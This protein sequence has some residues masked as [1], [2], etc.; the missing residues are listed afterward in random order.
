VGGQF[1]VFDNST[2]ICVN[3]FS[4]VSEPREVMTEDGPVL[5]GGIDDDIA[6]LQP[7]LAKMASPLQQLDPAVYATLATVIKEEYTKHGHD[8]TVT[9]IWQR[10][11]KGRLTEDRAV[12]QRLLDLADM[13][14]PF[15]KGGA[16]ANYFE[17][18][19]NLD[20]SNSFLVFELQE[21]SSNPHLKGV[22]QM[23][24][25]YR[26]TQ[27]M[28]EERERQ[29]AFILDEAKETLVGNG[30]DDEAM[31]KFLEALYLRVRKYN[32]CAITASQDVAH[33]MASRYGKSIWNQ[34]A[35]ILMGRQ[36]DN[37]IEAIRQ[38]EAIRMDENLRRLLSSLGGGGGHFKEWYVHSPIFKGVIRSVLNPSTLLLFSN[39]AEDNVPLDR[40]QA[41]GLEITQAIDRVLADRGVEEAT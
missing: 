11:Q 12:D 9:H 13:L 22:V 3:P 16:Y 31:A 27:E 18:R 10:Y 8:T 33:W 28:L 26:I 37:S 24:L 21:L 29:K 23:I 25:M 36:S 38:G 1:V 6:M 32:G 5:C 2:Y 7:L 15:A 39:R 35:F 19:S 40:Y 41:Q 20:F 30:D 34:S 4:M 14:A 17:G